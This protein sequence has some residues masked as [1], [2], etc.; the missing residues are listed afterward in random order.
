MSQHGAPDRPPAPDSPADAPAWPCPLLPFLAAASVWL[1][2]VHAVSRAQAMEIVLVGASMLLVGA[3]IGLAGVYTSTLRR[4]FRLLLFQSRGW[5]YG[6]LS[7]RLLVSLFWTVWALAISFVLLLRFHVYGGVEWAVLA[8]TIPMFALVFAALHRVFVKELRPDAAVTEALVW[9]RRACPALMLLLYVGALALGSDLPRHA[10]LDAAIEAHR[11]GAAAWSGSALVRE[12]LHWGAY[13]D[14]LEAYALGRLGS[15][16]SLWA[17]LATGAG[18]LAI[19]Y[20]VCLALSCFRIPRAGFVQARLAPRTFE[21]VFAAAAV[22]TFLVGFVYFPL[23]ARLDEY[24]ARSPDPARVRAQVERETTAAARQVF[25]RIDDGHYRPGTLAQI[26]SARAA[27]LGAVG[28]AAERFRR[29]VD[30][31]FERLED[32]AVGE[33]LDWYYSLPAEYGRIGM[34]L[35]GRLEDYLTEQARRTFEQEKWYR[36]LEAV[37]ETMLSVEEQA[38]AAYER[39]VRDTLDRNR[40]HP[41]PAAFD[42]TLTASLEDIVQP[43][44]HQDVIPAA[45][46][47]G[48]AGVAAG[49]GSAAAGGIT[50]AIVQKVTA[51]VLGKQVLELAAKAPLK[52]AAGKLAAAVAGGAALGSLLP[53][54]GTAVGAVVGGVLV[55]ASVGVAVDG[56]LLELEEALSRDDF[57]RELV[58]AIR[59]ARGEFADEYLG[60]P[61]DGASGRISAGR[62]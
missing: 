44:L 15:V 35:Q 24:V 62:G 37:F 38:R 48:A 33:Y 28:A 54:A 8:A 51:K 30:A 46:R 3:P 20:N 39:T 10:S 19:F 52:A 36:S 53:G 40:V 22:A 50:F 56:A 59:Q 34:M 29:E 12:A 11:A 60:R 58:A 4:Q 1:A 43:S 25:E 5:L 16:D 6:L 7:R 49:A 2:A 9:S 13:F 17:L 55:G 61:A 32:E 57:E 41:E 14:G 27:A 26:A 47:L 23:L 18:N 21:N 42:V 45:H 31:A